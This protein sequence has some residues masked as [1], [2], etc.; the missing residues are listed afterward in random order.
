MYRSEAHPDNT[1]D[2]YHVR[3]TSGFNSELTIHMLR[4]DPGEIYIGVSKEREPGTW[5]VQ[6][7][8]EKLDEL[9]TVLLYA[10]LKM[11]PRL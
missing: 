1:F 3:S 10:K 6:L 2:I 8:P 4:D 11:R 5:W 9:L 7:Y